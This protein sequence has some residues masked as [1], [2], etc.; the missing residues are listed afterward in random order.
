MSGNVWRWVLGLTYILAVATIW[1]ASSFVVQSVVDAGVSP[2]LITFICNSLFVVY[3]PLFEISRYLEDAYGSIL[4]WRSKRSHLLE[5][6][7]SEKEALLGQ[8]VVISDASEVSGVVVREDGNGLDEK[9]RWTRMRVAKVSL[10][11]CPFWFLAQL[12]FNLSLK[13]TT[14]TSNTILSSASS[15]F[16]FLVSL[17]FLGE[18]FTWLKLFSVLLCMSGTIIVSIGDSESDSTASAKTPLLGDILALISAA[19]Y[20][21]YITLIRKKLPGD[22]ERSGSFSMAQLLGF[23]GLF[24]FFIFLPVALLLNFTKR[25]RFDALTLEQFGLVV[26]KGMPNHITCKCWDADVC[27]AFSGLLDNVLSDYLWAKAVL[28]TTTTVATAGLTIQVPLAAIVDS[29]SGNKPSFT[30]YIGAAAVMV[31]FA[32]I[33]IPSESKETAIE[34]ESETVVS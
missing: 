26:G 11:I 16:T 9:G 33:N 14:V 7:E 13:Y 28:L 17:L 21:V 3:L 30:D 24:N 4:F 8:D 2:F 31:G 1:I 27:L 6:A 29:L 5:L 25:E 18:R 12:T 19:L 23:L 34:L 22:D 32:G 15:L 20:A 10:L